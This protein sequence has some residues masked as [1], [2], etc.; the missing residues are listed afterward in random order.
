MMITKA[1]RKW[2]A[3]S[4]PL[5]PAS[6]P[7]VILPIVAFAAASAFGGSE[8]VVPEQPREQVLD[9]QSMIGRELAAGNKKIV[10]PPGRYRVK[11]GDGTHLVLRDL[12]NVQI[13]ADGVEMIC[14]ATV[15]AVGLERCT[16]VMLRG[17]TIDYDPLP[18]TQGRIVAL[19]PEKCWVEFELFGGYPEDEL[20]ERIEIFDPATREL[21]R[22]SHYG[23]GGFERTGPRRYRISKGLNYRYRPQADTEQ[24]G[25]LLVTNNRTPERGGVHAVL[26]TGCA[27]VTLQD[28]TLYASPTFGFLEIGCTGSTYLRC[29]IDRRTPADDPVPRASPRLRSLNADAFHSKNAT[30]GPAIIE[31][32]AHWQGDDCVNINGRYYYV[33]GSQGRT[34][35]IVAF[36]KPV[37]V[38]GDLVGFLPYA[39]GPLP[40]ARVAGIAPAAEPLSAAEQALLREAKLVEMVRQQFSRNA[41]VYSLA[42]DREINPPPGSAVCASSRI[43]NGFL[44]RN[45]DFG[46]N[47]SRGILIKASHGEVSGNRIHRS[48]MA[49][50]LISPEFEWMEA[51]CSSDV[52][53]KDNAFEGIGR[54]PVRILAD[55]GNGKPLPAGAH[56]NISV[57]NNRFENC[58]WPLVEAHS[59]TG[60]TVSGNVWPQPEPTGSGAAKPGKPA[61]PVLLLNCEEVGGD[62]HRHGSRRD[63]K[64]DQR[65]ARDELKMQM[66]FV[67]G[68]IGVRIGGA[69]KAN[70]PL[71]RR[72][73]R[74]PRQRRAESRLSQGYPFP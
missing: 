24:A 21:R 43:G 3:L 49:A 60:L 5:L 2:T 67:G 25:D 41:Q 37:I 9:L 16:N 57:L 11:P 64:R 54:T 72:N 23:W 6:V 29:R 45:C 30:K 39:G 18:F 62:G 36:D 58:P 12:D 32:F 46:D 33:A 74:M 4:G 26:L 42:L 44:V 10:I 40:Q 55:G 66:V 15:Q 51:G 61:V 7:L 59:V 27:N 19:G 22:A 65:L 38:P 52:V 68:G 73:A 71:A 35:R 17:L 70:G 50:V 69:L 31:C 48:R 8:P 1:M 63:H 34:V 20:V 13:I 47:R 28:V 53:V 14:T 56:R